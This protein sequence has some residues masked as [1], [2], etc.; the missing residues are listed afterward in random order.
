MP[1]PLPDAKVCSAYTRGEDGKD[2]SLLAKQARWAQVGVRRRGMDPH[3]MQKYSSAAMYLAALIPHVAPSRSFTST[4]D[5]IT[6]VPPPRPHSAHRPVNVEKKAPPPRS[7]T[8]GSLSTFRT[9][10]WCVYFWVSTFGN[11]VP[12]S[13]ALGPN[14]TD[15]VTFSKF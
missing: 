11:K 5:F 4:E 8:L 13:P 12:K 10:V 1:P 6:D 3:N 14:T 2:L 9:K 7:P 15:P